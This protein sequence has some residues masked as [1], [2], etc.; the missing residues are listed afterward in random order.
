MLGMLSLV[1]SLY[2]E[3]RTGQLA[4]M[5]NVILEPKYVVGMINDF[6]LKPLPDWHN[7]IDLYAI[8]GT[9]LTGTGTENTNVQELRGKVTSLYTLYN[10]D[11]LFTFN[12]GI[13]SLFAHHLHHYDPYLDPTQTVE[14][15]A[16]E[17]E[18]ITDETLL[19]WDFN[20]D[21]KDDKI[22]STFHNIIYFTG[23]RIAPN[24]LTYQPTL[25]FDWTNEVFLW[26]SNTNPRLSFYAN[27]EFWFA[28]KAGVTLINLHDGI[29]ATKRELL[30][31]Y[32]LHYYFSKRTTVYLRT[33]GYNNLNRGTSPSQPTGFRD[34]SILGISHTF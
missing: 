34:G 4:G 15:A 10:K 28:R 20:F 6:T 27:V 19:G 7:H 24:L 5:Q 32:G 17:N 22:D 2:F 25:G 18:L 31:D 14:Y 30:L 12:M 3:N 11:D 8:Y 33:Y 26:G 1:T 29:G 9:T 23:K 13:Y 21:I 16:E